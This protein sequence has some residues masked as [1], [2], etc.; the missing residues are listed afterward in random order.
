MRTRIFV[1]YSRADREWLDRFLLHVAV[2]ERRCPV[3]VWSDTRIA[4]GTDWEKEIESSLASAR[5]AALL[6]SPA[7]MASTFI[8]THE[9]PRIVAHTEQGLRPYPIVV[10]PVAWKLDDFLADLQARPTDG[11]ALSLRSE[12]EVDFEFEKVAYELAGLVG[13]SPRASDDSGSVPGS[14]ADDQVLL[15]I[16]GWR[17][18]YNGTRRLRLMIEETD[19]SVVR[20]TLEYVD[21]N[22]V[23]RI[24]GA[25]HTAGIADDPVWVQIGGANGL[26]DGKAL[27]L[28]EID[29]LKR[30][31]RPIDFDGEY[32]LLAN[33]RRMAGAWF[34]GQRLVGSLKLE[35]VGGRTPG[36]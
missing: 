17:G 25:I 23:T 9:M 33:A 15:L 1:S 30:G 32:R 19:G 28:R 34:S 22:T 2:L 7:F 26:A 16:G 12:G 31:S 29:Y 24:E 20:G 14:R 8:W 10:R 18:A 21:E 6:I 11:T 35:R 5:V 27:T 13:S 36:E 3:D 4:A